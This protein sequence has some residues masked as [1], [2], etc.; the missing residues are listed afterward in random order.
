MPSSHDLWI[1]VPNPFWGAGT[2]G[3]SARYPDRKEGPGL[4]D[5]P[6]FVEGDRE[7]LSRLEDPL[8]L[9]PQ[10][11]RYVDCSGVGEAYSWTEP[12]RLSDQVTVLAFRDRSFQGGA[13]QPSRMLLNRLSNQL[14]LLAFPFLRDCVRVAG[15]R[16]SS[17]ISVRIGLE[18]EEDLDLTVPVIDIVERNGLKTLQDR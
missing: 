1:K 4:P 2:V 3:F 7:S 6:F 9:F 15:L 11:E 8:R 5:V 14:V 13:P 16:L 17:R 10:R 12:I 18:G